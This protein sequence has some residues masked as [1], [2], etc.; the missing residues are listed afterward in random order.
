MDIL[1]SDNELIEEEDYESEDREEIPIDNKKKKKTIEERLDDLEFNLTQDYRKRRSEIREIKKEWLKITKKL[2]KKKNQV[3]SKAGINKPEPIPDCLATF[4]GVPKGTVMARTKLGGKIY[5]ECKERGLVYPEDNRIIRVD[6]ELAKI[7]KTT[8]KVN[9]S[10][11]IKD[12][13]LDQA[14]NFYNLSSY[15]KRCYN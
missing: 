13:E 12:R 7:F 5:Q 11:N 8:K 14:I 1:N 6:D 3:D 2:E 15:I 10:T 9:K 4:I